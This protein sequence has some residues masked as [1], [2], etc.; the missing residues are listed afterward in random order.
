LQR[1]IMIIY[2]SYTLRISH[3]KSIL[4]ERK[5][6]NQARKPPS[7]WPEILGSPPRR[8]LDY[9]DILSLLDRKSEAMGDGVAMRNG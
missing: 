4:V 8:N 9:T 3:E 2:S 5:L 6:A 7:P 1:N